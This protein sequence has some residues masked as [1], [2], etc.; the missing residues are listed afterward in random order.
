MKI[1]MTPSSKW[2]GNK[3]K[4]TDQTIKSSDV[5]IGKDAVVEISIKIGPIDTSGNFHGKIEITLGEL[6]QLLGIIEEKKLN[7][8]LK[9]NERGAG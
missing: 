9:Q 6:H 5:K 8:L 2:T 7:L 3:H 4:I 1:T